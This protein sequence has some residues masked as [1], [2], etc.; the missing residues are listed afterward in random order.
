MTSVLGRLALWAFGL[1]NTA[2]FL[3]SLW[4]GRAYYILPLEARSDHELHGMFAPGAPW[5]VALGVLGSALMLVMMIYSIRK[6][7]VRY[8]VFGPI[9]KWLH[10]HI[11]CGIFG[12][13]HIVVHGGF[14]MPVGLIAVGFWCMVVVALSGVFGRYVHG[15]LPRMSGGQALAREQA[16]DR[17]A[18]LRADLVLQTATVNAENISLAVHLVRDFDHEAGTITEMWRL[19]RDMYRR[20]RQI[21][22]L[23]TAADL[24]PKSRRI[25][26]Q[27]LAEQLK[28]KR[29]L[30]GSRLAHRLLRYWHLFHRPLAGAMYVIAFIHIASAVLLGG[31]LMRLMELF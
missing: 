10:F 25:A 30:E 13:L 31:S 1:A 20:Q 9:A 28:L 14:T 26:R 19:N 16:L 4:L 22:N 29:G 3:G 15:L 7:L 8:E 12:P 17:L 5:G 27:A 21:S 6:L 24:K 23:L 18:D 2:I 11:L